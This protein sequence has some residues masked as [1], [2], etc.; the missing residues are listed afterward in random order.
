MRLFQVLKKIFRWF[1]RFRYRK[2]YGVHSPFAFNFITR[3]IYEK[4]CYYNYAKFDKLPASTKES[5]S[6]CKLLFRL[7]NYQQPNKLLYLSD[8]DDI[9]PVF[10]WAKSDVQIFGNVNNSYK[11]DFVYINKS[12]GDSISTNQFIKSLLPQ[13]HSNSMFVM[14]GIG[15][16]KEHKKLWKELISLPQ[17][18]ISFDLYDIGILFFDL[19]KNKQDYLVNF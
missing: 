11:L 12:F 7:V 14:F 18:G 13:L 10:Q 5:K 17:A 3:V 6:I 19:S 16:T 8:F 1:K 2:G 9:T 15:H 4:G